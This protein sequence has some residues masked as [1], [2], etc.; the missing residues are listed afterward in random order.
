MLLALE[1]IHLRGI[2]HGNLTLSSFVWSN[3][4]YRWKLAGLEYA[5]YNGEPSVP[6]AANPYTS[7]ELA[8]AIATQRH[9]VI[10]IDSS[11]DIWSMGKII[12]KI[13]HNGRCISSR[14]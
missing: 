12:L 4:D 6:P 7:P 2:A 3:D 14:A 10:E 8:A 13:F 11:T 1:D 5:S 9:N